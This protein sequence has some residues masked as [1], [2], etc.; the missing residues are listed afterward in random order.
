M[1]DNIL[2]DLRD[3]T[4][5][6]CLTQLRPVSFSEDTK[7]RI[8]VHLNAQWASDPEGDYPVW[9]RFDCPIQSEEELRALIETLTTAY[10]WGAQRAQPD[11]R[12]SHDAE[13]PEMTP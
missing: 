5:P 13:R 12:V 11:P 9:L 4:V 7:L 10:H 6:W 1:T 8:G 2:Q 3:Q